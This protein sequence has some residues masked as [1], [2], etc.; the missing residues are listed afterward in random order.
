VTAIF[1]T[2]T[3][4]DIGKTFVTAAVIRHLRAAREKVAAIKPVVSGFS[5]DHVATSDPGILLEAL[6]RAVTAQEIERIAPWRFAAPM[7]PD[8]AAAREGRAIDFNEVVA[9]SRQQVMANRNGNLLIEGIGGI[10]VPLDAD[11][12]VLDWITTLK[13]PSLVVTGSY[14]GTISHTLTALHVLSA[15]N[16]DI[17]GVVV[18]ESETSGAPLDET[19]ASIAR[20]LDRPEVIALPRLAGGT[21]D[22]PAFARIASLFL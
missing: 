4:T 13:I 8:I 7:S 9:F 6:G 21:T 17:A 11:H 2:A 10:M 1:V 12:T 14:L 20:F 18:S 16:L 3:G 19:C 15:R 22:H 5:M